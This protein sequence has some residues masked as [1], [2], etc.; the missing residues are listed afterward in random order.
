M[1]S[2]PIYILIGSN[3]GDRERNLASARSKL[4]YVEGL[5]ITATSSIYLTE[6]MDM[7]TGSPRFLNQVVKADYAYRPNELLDALERIEG[8]LGRTDKGEKQP[9]TADLD[10]LLFGEDIIETER[11]SIPHRELLNRAFAMV[12]LLQIDPDAVHP[13]TGEPISSYLSDEAAAAVLL[14]KDNVARQI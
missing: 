6:P 8:Q 5:E 7:E 14:Y 13:V 3:L 9:R 11:L 12:P 2:T 4:E 1:S 10:I